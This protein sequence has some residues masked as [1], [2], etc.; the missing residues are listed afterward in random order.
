M[1]ETRTGPP[2]KA[3]ERC[4]GQEAASL[5]NAGKVNDMDNATNSVALPPKIAV[6]QRAI[7]AD[8]YDRAAAEL[9][10]EGAHVVMLEWPAETLVPLPRPGR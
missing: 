6:P 7:S 3:R 1:N 5:G 10:A 4:P 9:A 2:P 8:E